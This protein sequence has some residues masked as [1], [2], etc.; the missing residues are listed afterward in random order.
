MAQGLGEYG[1]L[2]GGGGGSGSVGSGLSDIVSA[3][4]NA[5][6]N[7]T[8]KTWIA[9]AFFLFVLWFFLIRRR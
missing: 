4:E 6:R 1:G 9:I 5:L 3:I 7:P 2:V 8:P